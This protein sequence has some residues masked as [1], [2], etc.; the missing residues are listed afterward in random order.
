M[1]VFK[2]CYNLT[3]VVISS[4]LGKSK[5]MP[6]IE[7][8]FFAKRFRFADAR[9]VSRLLCRNTDTRCP[10]VIGQ[11]SIVL[12]PI[13]YFL[14]IYVTATIFHRFQ[15]RGASFATSRWRISARRFEN[16]MI[17]DH[18]RSRLTENIFVELTI[19]S[20]GLNK[21]HD[22]YNQYI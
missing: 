1:G 17:A 19:N 12:L 18:N 2:L 6:N 22:I 3:L 15:T 5:Q 7:D 10:C 21:L 13:L 4:F 9:G 8:E 16:C 14:L 20:P 11:P